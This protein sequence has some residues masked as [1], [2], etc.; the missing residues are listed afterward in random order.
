MAEVTLRGGC[1]DSIVRLFGDAIHF[2]CPVVD[3]GFIRVSF[4]AT[5]L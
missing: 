5:A 3:P 1:H 2:G 4:H